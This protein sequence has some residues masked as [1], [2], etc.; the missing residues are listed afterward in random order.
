MTRGL[1]STEGVRPRFSAGMELGAAVPD[2]AELDAVDVA[3]LR[4]LHEVALHMSPS[5][6]SGTSPAA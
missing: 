3:L 4:K 5:W 2:H 1:L 6:A